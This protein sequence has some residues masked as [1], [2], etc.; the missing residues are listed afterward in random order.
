M[1]KQKAPYISKAVDN[2]AQPNSGKWFKKDMP[3]KTLVFGLQPEMPW[4][5]LCRCGHG[6]ASHKPGGCIECKCI[7]FREKRGNDG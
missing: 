6:K 1:S 4:H 2:P 5:K 3:G 7:K